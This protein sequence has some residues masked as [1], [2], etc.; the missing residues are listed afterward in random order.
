MINFTFENREA[1]QQNK[2]ETHYKVFRQCKGLNINGE[3][4][5]TCPSCRKLL[6]P[7]SLTNHLKT[8]K[9]LNAKFN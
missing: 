3:G 6:K 8:K 1:S 5:I 4:F 9:C 2:N 7:L